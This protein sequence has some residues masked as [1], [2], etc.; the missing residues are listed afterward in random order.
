MSTVG[1]PADEGEH[2]GWSGAD[3]RWSLVLRRRRAWSSGL[4]R[5]GARWPGTQRLWLKL[6]E[7][8]RSG[9]LDWGMENISPSVPGG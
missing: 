4:R 6:V 5:A 9:D 7:E 1:L 2:G 3:F 8:E